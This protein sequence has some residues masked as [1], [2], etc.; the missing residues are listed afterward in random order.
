[1]GVGSVSAFL[2]AEVWREYKFKGA[3]LQL[4]RQDIIC[5]PRQFNKIQGEL[6]IT[7][8]QFTQK[9]DNENFENDHEFFSMF[10]FDRI[11]SMDASAYENAS[12]VH[13][14]NLPVPDSMKGQFDVIYDGGTTEHV[15]N[16]PQVLK[17]TYDLLKEGGVAIHVLP[18]TNHVDHGYYMFSPSLFHDYYLVN[19]MEILRSHIFEYSPHINNA[20]WPVYN[21]IP[22]DF[23]HL[24]NGGWGNEMLAINLVVKKNKN[25]TSDKIPR[26]GAY[27]NF[28]W[29]T[30]KENN[31]VM[32]LINNKPQVRHIHKPKGTKK[33]V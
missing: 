21:Y 17:N 30:Q 6:K 1:M 31:D 4:G 7:L 33:N 10:G 13:D 3:L 11:E 29:Q 19:Q 22:K 9:K 23:A 5:T 14:L 28:D 25:S 12:M 2:F 15:F 16:T 8:D 20:V 26:P 24:S 32:P 27:T 18:S